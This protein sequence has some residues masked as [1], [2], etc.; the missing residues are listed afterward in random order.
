MEYEQGPRGGGNNRF[1]DQRKGNRGPWNNDRRD[2]FQN[3]RRRF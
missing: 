3:K 1:D 2:D